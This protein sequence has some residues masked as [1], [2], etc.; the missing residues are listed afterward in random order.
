VAFVPTR[1][2]VALFFVMGAISAV[3]AQHPIFR[4]STDLVTVDATVLGRDGRP[5]IGLGP[6]D[7]VLSV[8]GRPR[9]LISAEFV[10]QEPT[11]PRDATLP[12]HHFTSNEGDN[13]GR[14]VI[15]AVDDMHIRRLEGRPAMAAAGRFL[16]RLDPMDRA[17]V[18]TLS[19]LG[20]L[21]FTRDRAALKRQLDVI[22]GAT[23]PVRLLLNIGLAEAL[24]I[25]DGGRA[26]LAEVVLRECG[27][28]LAT[29]TNPARAASD[30]GADRNDCPEQVEMESRAAAQHAR[31]Q[32]RISLSALDALVETLR[33]LD[34]PKTIVL[35]SEGMV[36]DPRLVDVA[37]LAAK[38]KDSR[39]AIYVLHME[40]PITEAAEDRTSPTFLRD[41]QLR[42]DGL[43]RLAGATRG[44]VFRLVGSDPRPFDRIAAELSGY[45]LLAFE[46]TTADRDGRVHRVSVKLARGG[47]ELRARPAFR[48]PQVV[49]S[50]RSREQDLVTLLRGT[51][52]A[53]ELPVRV[54]TH[55]YGEPGTPRVRIVVTT[56]A[57]AS[58]GAAGNVLLGYVL[59]D[60]QGVIAASGA[61][62]SS[63]AREAFSTVIPAGA[64][65][66]R[67]A[68]I[69]PLGRRGLVQ[70]SF[71]AALEK[72]GSVRMSDVMIAHATGSADGPLRPFVDRVADA[73]VTAYVE[74]YDEIAGLADVAVRF[75]IT[76]ADS[77]Q[78]LI[79][80]DATVQHR[81]GGT[82]AVGRAIVDLGALSPGRYM[83]RA[84]IS[85]G[86]QRLGQVSRPFTYQP[87][88]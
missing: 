75:Q 7:F 10:T 28:S 26:R 30:A 59:T 67:V 36:L 22:V 51:R 31:T 6:D 70:R 84:E 42:G 69:D 62:A 87:A 72:M 57:D 52:G 50:P 45:Y 85:R 8:D 32:A 68:G 34:G 40:A 33:T 76:R 79:G 48:L 46:A 61:Q 86:G 16:D 4:A 54:A 19:R 74:L 11:S 21:Q 2:S 5:A 3:A 80:L 41:L 15:V 47:G 35:L 82:F 78:S 49:P 64:Y 39:V 14:Q 58:D 44:A 43:D 88:P 66:L 29:Y 60:A 1:V 17:A 55:T 25:A 73:R 9:R 27:R 77:S 83:A 37:E 20:T 53:S 71:A 65:T 56:E 23:D 63:G 38:A 24:E 18:T 12:S 81:E 13:L